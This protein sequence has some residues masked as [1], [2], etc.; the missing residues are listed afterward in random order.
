MRLL[1]EIRIGKVEAE[2]EW[3]ESFAP[4]GDLG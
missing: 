2:R 1:L 4:E 3:M